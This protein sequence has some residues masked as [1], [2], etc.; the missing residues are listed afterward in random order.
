VCWDIGNALP[1]SVSTGAKISHNAAND[2][3]RVSLELGGKSPF[4]IFDD[5]N[6][7]QATEWALYGVKINK[8]DL[9]E[10]FLRF[11][12]TRDKIVVQLLVCSY[13]KASTQKSLKGF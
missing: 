1:G 5:S 10:N 4:I 2:I 8:R 7:E 6:V 12:G 9:S 11:C 13:K 3:K